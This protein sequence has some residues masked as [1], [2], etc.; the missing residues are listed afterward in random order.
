MIRSMRG[1]V[2]LGAALG[3]IAVVLMGGTILY[4]TMSDRLHQAFDDGLIARG[5]FLASLVEFEH[6]TFEAELDY[7]ALP[8]F[9]SEQDPEYFQIRRP[10]GEVIER[11][12]SLAGRDLA[13]PAGPGASGT[14]MTLQ[15]P[16]GRPGRAAI[17]AARARV[18]SEDEEHEAHE[19]SS[20]VLS[21]G[22]AS[23]VVVTVARGTAGLHAELANLRR[24]LAL[25]GLMVIVLVII[26]LLLVVRRGLAP[27]RRLSGQIEALGPDHLSARLALP[28]A[29]SELG[30]VVEV[31][32]RLLGRLQSAIERE[33]SF[34]GDVAH[35]LRT[36]LAG[37]RSTLEVA[38]SRERDP[39][40]SRRVMGECLGIAG[41]MQT[42]TGNLLALARLDRGQIG[43]H[44]SP[45]EVEPLLKKCWEPCDEAA[46]RK[47]LVVHWDVIPGLAVQ[48]DPDLLGLVL[49]NLLDNAVAYADSGGE[50]E[51][52]AR[53]DDGRLR[54]TIRNTGSRLSQAEA[55][56]ACEPFWRGDASRSDP[57]H[58]A[59]LGLSIVRRIVIL[60]G[61]EVTIW[62]ELGGWFNIEVGLPRCEAREFI[63]SLRGTPSPP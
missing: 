35:E 12:P 8:E 10:D 28:G 18:E 14:L 60:L 34:T 45:V 23:E 63:S 56:Q 37:L 54:L 42:M 58:H 47:P 7:R 49:T 31:T 25:I 26:V 38:L 52:A 16:D 3:T 4:R 46:E 53:V 39:E 57:G 21:A 20:E 41:A 22:T 61:G 6:G 13:L 1:R 44:V 59:G 62:S 43:V 55:Q 24:L 19:R 36:P 40:A 29:P 50:I 32:N 9:A 2:I 11:S 27:L 48:T 15:L 30:P 51:I 17:V 5:R 33:R